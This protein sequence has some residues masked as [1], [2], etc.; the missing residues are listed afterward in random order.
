M[1]SPGGQFT[2]TETIQGP[3]VLTAAG[4]RHLWSTPGAGEPGATTTMQDDGD[5]VVSAPDGRR[6]WFTATGGHPGASLAL[7]EDGDVG[8]VDA[9]SALWSA[10]AVQDTLFAGERLRPGWSLYSPDRAC[11][12]VMEKTGTLM[13]QSASYGPLWSS[14]GS[15]AADASAEV[16]GDGNLVVFDRTG[17]VTWSAGVH[18]PAGTHLEVTNAALG[19]LVASR[20]RWIWSSG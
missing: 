1:A 17:R 5:L 4:G 8:V 10:H 6:I 11:R 13:L 19:L 20:G 7:G 9:T 15:R 3:L 2:L 18:G 16:L 14:V 12:L